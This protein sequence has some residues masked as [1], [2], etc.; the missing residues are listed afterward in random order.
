MPDSDG[1][2]RYAELSLTAQTSY[3]QLYEAASVAELARTVADLAGSF[4]RKRVKGREYWYFQFS[5]LSG[6]LRQIYVGPDSPQ[7]RALVAR[8]D[9]VS[10]AEKLLPLAR[11]AVALGCEPILPRHFRVIRRLSEYG[12]FKAGGV[13]IGTHAFL[14]HGNILGVRWGDA[15]RTQDVD[16]AH[17]GKNIA[18]A[19]P[20]DIEVDTHGAIE[21]LGMGFL[22]TLSL[23]A[24]TGGAYVNPREPDF[25]LDFVTTL[26]RGGEAPYEHPKLHVTL[27]P[28]KFMEFSLENVVQGAVFCQ[29]GAVV[30][31]LPHPARY[32]LHKLLVFGERSGTFLQKAGKDLSQCAALLAFFKAHR[33]WE[34]EEAWTDLIGRGKGWVIR[35]RQGLRALDRL[36]PELRV[37][38]WLPLNADK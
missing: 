27:Q 6:T 37:T 15:A 9:S 14:A 26:H 17:S 28:L 32:A 25:R 35:A 8:R 29:E 1:L 3:A 33:S 16:F 5:D 21:S 2:A 13:L 7:V 11:S 23:A 34:I 31:N 18:V 38:H 19:L 30:V 36:A 12:F 24:R 10:G 20:A 4:A 22:P